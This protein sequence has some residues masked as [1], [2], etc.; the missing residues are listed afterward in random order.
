[1]LREMAAQQ[2][3]S[4]APLRLALRPG[5]PDVLSLRVLKRRGPLL[6]APLQLDL[7]PVLSATARSRAQARMGVAELPARQ[8]LPAATFINLA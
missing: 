5:G 1:M 6:E 7:L 2:H 3:A 8:P 4:P